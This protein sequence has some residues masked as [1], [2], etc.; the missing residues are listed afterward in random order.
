MS[1]NRGGGAA[2][3]VVLLLSASLRPA[4]T[5][6]GP[7]LPDVGASV[8]ADA[9]ELGVLGAI[10]LLA[11]ALCSP[12][13][14]RL[15]RAKGIEGALLLAMAVLTAGILVR[16]LG[17]VTGL[18]VG[19]AVAA[20]AIGIAN[21]VTPVL[22]KRDFLRPAMATA[23]FT[24][25]LSG[26]AAL[27][28][29]T[30]VPLARWLGGWR[31]ALAVWALLSA[32]CVVVLARHARRNALVRTD[33]R[34]VDATVRRRLWRSPVA[35]RV[36]VFFGLQSMTFYTFVTWLPTIEQTMGIPSASAG[37]HLLLYQVL[38]AAAGLGIGLIM[39]GRHDHRLAAVLVSLPVAVASV[40]LMV[41]PGLVLLWVALAAAGAGSALTVALTLVVVKAGSA[42]ETAA[43]SGMAQSF[44]YLIAALGPLSAGAAV[45]FIGW[46]H[47]LLVVAGIAGV[48]VVLSLWVGRDET[49]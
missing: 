18:W 19:T 11:F 21:V 4:V 10:P 2:L 24:A 44:G 35:W 8:G 49:I 48:Q 12:F 14:A 33:V 20:G 16:S 42:D 27:A 46:S 36:T 25:A 38:G 13:G 7:L 30:A 43:L 29:G 32:S 15:A 40:G 34:V 17:G 6:V 39:E 23:A 1:R 9:L 37:W 41:H 22:V 45:R 5:S 47:V 3:A 28:S 31:E 26:S